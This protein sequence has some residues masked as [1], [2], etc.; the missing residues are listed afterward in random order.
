[1]IYYLQCF[2][3]YFFYTPK[4]KS[5]TPKNKKHTPDNKS[6]TPSDKSYTPDNKLYVIYYSESTPENKSDTPDNKKHTENYSNRNAG[7]FKKGVNH[8]PRS[9]T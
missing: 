5:D 4:N 1:M 3:G 6:Y 8:L 2:S 9:L 7:R